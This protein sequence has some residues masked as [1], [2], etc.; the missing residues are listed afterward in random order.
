MDCLDSSAARI[1]GEDLQAAPQQGRTKQG[2]NEEGR[3]ENA[4]S[5]IKGK[6]KLLGA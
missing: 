1:F 3:G 6:L 2:H 4:V 5:I